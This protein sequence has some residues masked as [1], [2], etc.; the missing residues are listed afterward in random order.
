[1]VNDLLIPNLEL[2]RKQALKD[3]WEVVERITELVAKISQY[4]RDSSFFRYPVTSNASM[5][6]KKYNVQ[7]F[8]NTDPEKLGIEIANSSVKNKKGKV[9]VLLVNDNDEVEKAYGYQDD[10]LKEVREAIFEIATYFYCTHIMT[11]VT[12]C[13]GM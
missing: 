8:K 2:L 10:I 13:D 3:D 12:L 11:R 5:D 9:T 7:A 1:L 4:D 6:H